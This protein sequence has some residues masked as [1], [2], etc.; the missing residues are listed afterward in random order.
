MVNTHLPIAPTSRLQPIQAQPNLHEI[1]QPKLQ[2]YPRSGEK[3]ESLPIDSKGERRTEWRMEANRLERGLA[4][5]EWLIVAYESG[6]PFFTLTSGLHRLN[7]TSRKQTTRR[8]RAGVD[9]R[10]GTG[11]EA[12]GIGQRVGRLGNSIEKDSDV[13]KRDPDPPVAPATANKLPPDLDPDLDPDRM[14]FK[15]EEK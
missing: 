15:V 9:A 2:D 4:G 14:E 11:A 10:E 13:L 7:D 5:R 6:T 3:T 8:T 12:T 1:Q